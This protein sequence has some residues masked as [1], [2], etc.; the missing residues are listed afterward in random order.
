MALKATIYKTALNVADMDRQVY[1]DYALTVARHPSETDERMLMRILA[2]A[3]HADQ[4]LEFGRGISTDDEPDL[5]RKQLTGDIELWIELGT[6]DESR[7]RKA[8][9]RAREVVLYCY[10]G[11]AVPLWWEKNAPLLQR[12]DNLK[13]L[14]IDTESSKQLALMA[15]PGMRLQASIMDG[16]VYIS[17]EHAALDPVT[18]KPTVLM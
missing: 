9:G 13:V 3:L 16:E 14:E 18:I 2:F 12:F 5:W 15:A 17:S 1:A 11:R 6:P 10:G 8:C 7:L 4:E